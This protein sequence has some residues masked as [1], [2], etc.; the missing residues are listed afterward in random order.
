MLACF[1]DPTSSERDHKLH[2]DY[3]VEKG[4]E[5]NIGRFQQFLN[6]RDP[7]GSST[8]GVPFLT[9][10]A[11]KGIAGSNHAKYLI[12]RPSG[13]EIG[14]WRSAKLLQAGVAS[15]HHARVHEAWALSRLH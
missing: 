14:A 8:H 12:F 11:L 7:E 3:V 5:S 13:R 4:R 2:D 15:L 1:T 9:S 10:K 6:L